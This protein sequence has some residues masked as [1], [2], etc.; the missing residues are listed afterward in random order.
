[1]NMNDKI[2]LAICIGEAAAGLIGSALAL[3]LYCDGK[4]EAAAYVGELTALAFG[5]SGVGYVMSRMSK[6]RNDSEPP[7]FVNPGTKYIM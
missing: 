1:M 4:P 2:P 6:Q 5:L 3:S 7:I